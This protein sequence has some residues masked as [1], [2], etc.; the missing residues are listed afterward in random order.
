MD[1]FGGFLLLLECMEYGVADV[2]VSMV[3]YVNVD[4]AYGGKH[5]SRLN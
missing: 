5:C 2:A 1:S 3:R 4:S